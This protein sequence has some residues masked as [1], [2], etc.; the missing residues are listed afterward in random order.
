LVTRRPE[1]ALDTVSPRAWRS[2]Q[3]EARTSRPVH[4]LMPI[5]APSLAVALL[6]LPAAE[7]FAGWFVSR[8]SMQR[9][10][11]EPD[12]LPSWRAVPRRSSPSY[13]RPQPRRDV[14]FLFEQSAG[15]KN[16]LRAKC[17][18]MLIFRVILNFARTALGLALWHVRQR[19]IREC[20]HQGLHGCAQR[21]ACQ[22]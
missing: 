22:H 20:H 4:V 18:V 5:S 14:P 19:F 13:W 3:S 12:N 9:Q 7:R 10:A 11:S 2:S 8:R 1:L 17:L 21:C 15:R 6:Q 16:F